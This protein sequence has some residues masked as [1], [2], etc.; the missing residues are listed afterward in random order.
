MTQAQRWILGQ[1]LDQYDHVEAALQS[2][3]ERIR[4]EVETSA[5]PFVP[6]A[7]PLLDTIPGIGET[8]AQIIVAEIGVD[9]ER[10][11]TANHLAS[12]A[13]MCPGNNESAGN[14]RAARRPKAVATC[15]RRW[16]KPPG[17]RVT[18]R[19]RIWPRSI[20]AW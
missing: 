9:M 13:G 14:A 7:V 6:E 2:V 8:V 11:P 4:Q 15:G 3:E 10:F 17:R 5:D 20:N 18:K 1:L 12:W 16:C 19:G